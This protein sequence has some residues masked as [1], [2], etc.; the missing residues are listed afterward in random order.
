MILERDIWNDETVVECRRRVVGNESL[1]HEVTPYPQN[2]Y[3]AEMKL[4]HTGHRGTFAYP[5]V[6]TIPW[7]I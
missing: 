5:P 7:E 2:M 6:T 1:P 4:Y 3:Q